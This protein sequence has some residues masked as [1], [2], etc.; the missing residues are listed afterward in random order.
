MKRQ[1]RERQAREKQL[2]EKQAKDRE[3][4]M[5]QALNLVRVDPSILRLDDTVINGDLFQATLHGLIY[6]NAHPVGNNSEKHY[7]SWFWHIPRERYFGLTVA[8]KVEKFSLA[9]FSFN[10]NPDTVEPKYY[11]SIKKE[12]D[13]YQWTLAMATDK[14]SPYWYAMAH[15]CHVLVVLEY[16]MIVHLMP[17]H[18]WHIIT[19]PN[20]A[21]VANRHP[22]DIAEDPTVPTLYFDILTENIEDL[23]EVAGLRKWGSP[24][25]VHTYFK[26][27]LEDNMITLP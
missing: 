27:L 7:R 20:H 19:T 11:D 2:R 3:D 9:Y 14:Y 25:D 22:K 16:L 6:Q 5:R 17:N 4:K 24:T 26:Q 1:E 15:T 23:L 12:F 10:E 21:F 13:H 18:Q 8:E